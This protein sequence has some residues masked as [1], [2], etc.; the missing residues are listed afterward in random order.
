MFAVMPKPSS[1]IT[2][3][4]SGDFTKLRSSKEK[5]PPPCAVDIPKLKNSDTF[6][7]LQ[8]TFRCSVGSSLGPLLAALAKSKVSACQSS[9]SVVNASASMV[10]KT[11]FPFSSF[12]RA[13][14]SAPCLG[15]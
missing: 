15:M 5:V 2:P 11:L 1:A 10:C 9:A 12:I 13:R 3:E 8:A 6:S 14:T 4:G 7:E